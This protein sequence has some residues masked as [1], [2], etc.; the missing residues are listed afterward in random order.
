MRTV[1][2][3][4]AAGSGNRMGRELSKQYLSLGGKPILVH[5][6]NVFEKCPLVDALLVVVPPPDVEAV[7]TE[8]LPRWNLKKLAGVIPGG[9][10][11]QDSVRAG[12]ETLDR[13]TDI[14]IVHD[15]VRPFITAKLIEDC[16]RA[17]AEEGAATVGVPV[18]DT[19]KEVGADGRVMRTCDRNLLWLT[20]TPQAFRRD[21]IENAHRAAVRDGYRGTD[22]TS[23]VERL[24][25]AVRM[26]RGDYGNIKITTP[27]DLVIAEALL[28]ASQQ[29]EH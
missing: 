13:D 16:I 11:R 1:A 17:A 2:I 5:T 9:K 14:V 12:I 23:L 6:L 15:A 25:I 22:D 21:I 29:A 4:P 18:K 26:I 20:Q 3:V 28:A 7:R 8:M 27:E 24:G 19:V 10:E